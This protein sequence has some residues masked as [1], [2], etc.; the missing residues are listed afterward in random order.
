MGFLA[1]RKLSLPNL[2]YL[3]PFWLLRPY[4][5][6]PLVDTSYWM[7]P[8]YL[9]GKTEFTCACDVYSIGMPVLRL[10]SDLTLSHFHSLPA[11][12]VCLR[13]HSL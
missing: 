1:H 3:A 10:P 7:A 4:A 2:R 8:E 9:R 6:F 11:L 5:A 12:L 13:N